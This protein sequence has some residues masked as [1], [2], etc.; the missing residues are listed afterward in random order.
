MPRLFNKSHQKYLLDDLII[1][2]AFFT[3]LLGL[4][5]KEGLGE[6]QGL[7]LLNCSSIH[8]YFMRFPIDCYFLSK[9]LQV[10][11]IKKDLKPWKT[12]S[13]KYQ[14]IHSVL[15]VDARRKNKLSIQVGDYLIIE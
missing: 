5:P 12:S 6:Q 8:T 7:L 9:A 13:P 14:Q 10:I 11:S 15:E 1:A 4:L 2:R 3:R